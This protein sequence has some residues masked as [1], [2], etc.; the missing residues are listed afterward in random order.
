MGKSERERFKVIILTPNIKEGK[1]TE[2][3][4]KNVREEKAFLFCVF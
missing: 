2:F 1:I 3:F 4:F